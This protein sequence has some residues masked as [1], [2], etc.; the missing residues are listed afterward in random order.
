LLGIA[1]IITIIVNVII[2]IMVAI[3]DTLF[4]AVN[5]WEIS[6]LDKTRKDKKN[7]VKRADKKDASLSATR[8]S[9]LRRTVIR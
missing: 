6:Y 2:P 8:R 5:N 3:L 7:P 1:N 9:A 4:I